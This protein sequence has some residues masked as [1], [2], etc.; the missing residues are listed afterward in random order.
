MNMVYIERLGDTTMNYGEP[1]IIVRNS[2]AQGT[3]IIYQKSKA[4]N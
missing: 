1:E 2:N 3:F 4:T